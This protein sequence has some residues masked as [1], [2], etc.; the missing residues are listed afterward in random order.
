MHPPSCLVTFYTVNQCFVQ[1]TPGT[2]WDN[3]VLH[4]KECQQV[5][6]DPILLDD[7]GGESLLGGAQ[8]TPP[9]Q[10]WPGGWLKFGGGIN[11][12]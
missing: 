8:R 6:V 9:D 11:R 12:A 7:L 1:P 5:P 3:H 2:D 4:L 10:S